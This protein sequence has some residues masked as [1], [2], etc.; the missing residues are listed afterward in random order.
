LLRPTIE[1]SWADSTKRLNPQDKTRPNCEFLASNDWGFEERDGVPVRVWWRTGDQP[2]AAALADEIKNKVWPAFL[3]LGVTLPPSDV[4]NGRT[5]CY[6]GDGKLDVYLTNLGVRGL[7][8]QDGPDSRVAPTF[9]VLRRQL[10]ASPALLHGAFAHELMHAVQ[11]ANRTKSTQASYGWIRDAMANWAVD[12]VY[13]TTNQLE[14]PYASCFTK[15]PELPLQD[16]STGNCNDPS[17]ANFAAV[18]RNYGAYLYF[19]YLAKRRGEGVA[20]QVLPAM[21]AFDTGVEALNSIATFSTEWPEFAKRLWNREPIESKPDSFKVW[22]QLS[23]Q[24]ELTIDDSA[25]LNGSPT[26][27]FDLEASIPNLANRFYRFTFSDPNTRSFLFYNGF[28]DQFSAG[29]AIKV[30]ALWKDAAGTWQEEDWS[31]YKFVGL[32]RDLKNQRMSELAIIVSNAEHA[33]A[34]G[35][36]H[37]SKAPFIK[38][39]NLGCYKYSGTVRATY[40]ATGVGISGTR[41]EIESQLSFELDQ[42]MRSLT[43]SPSPEVLRLLNGQLVLTGQSYVA[44]VNY[45]AGPCQYRMSAI[46]FPIVLAGSSLASTISMNIFLSDLEITGS[47][48]QTYIDKSRAYAGV[49]ALFPQPTLPVTVSGANCGASPVN[50]PMYPLLQ[51]EEMPFQNPPV[52]SGTGALVGNYTEASPADPGTFSWSLSPQ[53]E[54]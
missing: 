35:S 54:P 26:G 30:L 45:N 16:M 4:N 39:S 40:Q 43:Y 49:A 53:N 10:A 21:G 52:A 12:V 48:I 38:A 47:P 2:F 13:G 7:T 32:C 6:G 8:V 22:D 5:V 41:Q 17:G 3:R 36:I 29:K 11:W 19:Q 28:Y 37:A 50:M 18:S 25:D 31:K 51:T 14:Q 23:E 24:A 44:S 9:I 15:K 42:S 33:P 34:N 46:S 27:K 20:A 1:G